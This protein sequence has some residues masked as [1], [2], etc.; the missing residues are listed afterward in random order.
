[1][2]ETQGTSHINSHDGNAS[3]SSGSKD[4]KHMHVLAWNIGK[5]LTTLASKDAVRQRLSIAE[6]IILTEVGWG[7]GEYS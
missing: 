2:L 7:R 4:S 3:F 1:M 6:I 5:S